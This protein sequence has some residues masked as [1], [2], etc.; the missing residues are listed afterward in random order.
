MNNSTFDI[1]MIRKEKV[2]L[3]LDNPIGNKQVNVLKEDLNV[4]WNKIKK[5]KPKRK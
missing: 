5:G 1:N 3:Q 2:Q 4:Y